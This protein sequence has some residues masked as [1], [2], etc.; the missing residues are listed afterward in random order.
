MQ[1]AHKT[2]IAPAQLAKAVVLKAQ[3][4]YRVCVIP[5][6]H[7]LVINWINGDYKKHYSM[8]NEAELA[9]LFPDCEVG[10]I[11]IFGQ[12]YGLD[13]VCDNYLK[14]APLVYMEAG[15]HRH[16]IQLKQREFQQLMGNADHATISCTPD[17]MEFYQHVH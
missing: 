6:S 2:N 11:P 12:A 4:D 9:E 17:T 7:L 15:D 1:T 8:V 10:A 5:A 14:H 16:V 3:D 13:V